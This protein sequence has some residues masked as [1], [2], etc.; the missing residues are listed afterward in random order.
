MRDDAVVGEVICRHLL[1]R[2][3]VV[4]GNDRL[5]PVELWAFD[6]ITMSKSGDDPSRILQNSLRTSHAFEIYPGA[7][8]IKGHEVLAHRL[9]HSQI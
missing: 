2:R 1:S 3:E 5:E 9:C 4:R 6:S 8:R 7:S